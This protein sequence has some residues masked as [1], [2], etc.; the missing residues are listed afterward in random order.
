M[1]IRPEGA[2]LFHADGRIDGQTCAKLIVVFC[3]FANAHDKDLMCATH[4]LH[5]LVFHAFA[6][7]SPYI[8]FLGYFNVCT[9]KPGHL[10]RRLRNVTNVAEFLPVSEVFVV[11]Q[12]ATEADVCIMLIVD[13]ELKYMYNICRHFQGW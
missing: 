2:E 6:S 12:N 3:N 1:K 8:I 5:V 13:E 11:D 9:C 7:D 10:Y 4:C